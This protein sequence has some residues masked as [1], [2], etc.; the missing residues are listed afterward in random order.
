MRQSGRRDFPMKFTILSV[1]LA[2][3]ANV[4]LGASSG[5]SA[6]P[7]KEVPISHDGMVT[8]PGAVLPPRHAQSIPSDTQ[9]VNAGKVLEV[10]DTDT[11]TYVQVTAEKGPLWLAV[12][13]MPV[14]K[15]A[16]VK[17]SNGIAMSNFY[18]KALSRTFDVIIFV[19]SLEVMMK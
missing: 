15:G 9:L 3:F 14:S 2:C 6:N 7:A 12:Y 10:L 13:K 5:E 8:K 19:D 4:A 11:Y 1:A 18:S 17:Y 16:N